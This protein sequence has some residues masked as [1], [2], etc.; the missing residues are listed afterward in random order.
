M[1]LAVDIAKVFTCKLPRY[2]LSSAIRFKLH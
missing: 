2:N 1:A